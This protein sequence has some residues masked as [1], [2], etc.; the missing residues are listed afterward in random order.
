MVCPKV[1]SAVAKKWKK[2]WEVGGIWT[3]KNGI[4]DEKPAWINAFLN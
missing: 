4:R 2:I 3:E 1:K